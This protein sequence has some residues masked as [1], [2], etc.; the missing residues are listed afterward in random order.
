METEIKKLNE[1]TRAFFS[2][3]RDFE[4]N[5]EVDVESVIESIDNMVE[6]LTIGVE[7]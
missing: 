4:D 7:I 3:L 5:T 2:A 1:A 6:Q